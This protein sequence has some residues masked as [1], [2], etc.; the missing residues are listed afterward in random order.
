LGGPQAGIII[1]KKRLVE[2]IAGNHLA[3]ALR[4]DK[5]V[6]AAL[7]ATLRLYLRP[8]SLPQ[9]LPVAAML[10]I[11]QEEL[12]RRAKI[13]QAQIHSPDLQV[14]IVETFAQM[15]S[16]ALPLEKIPSI[17]LKITSPRQ[18]PMKLAEK[19]RR[20]TPPII[21]YIQDEALLL[22]LRTVRED[23]LGIIQEALNTL[24]L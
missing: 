13:I 6:Y 17:A 1:G 4:C 21:G 7:E 24:N 3:R 11:S 5:L 16:G 14:D 2:K 8:D 22:N 19:L 10:T 9:H 20:H 23:E 15:G 18:S 12:T